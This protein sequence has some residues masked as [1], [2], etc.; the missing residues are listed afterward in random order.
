MAAALHAQIGPLEG[1]VPVE[2][3]AH[4]LDIGEI[5][6][7]RLDGLEG[8]LLTDRRRSFGSILANMAG[9]PRRARFT[10]AHELAHFLLERHE[11]SDAAGFA[12]VGA[13]MAEARAATTRQRQER[14]ANTF[15]IELLAPLLRMRPH[16]AGAADLSAAL[17]ARDD[18][19]ISL[20]AATWRYIDL[21]QAPLAAVVA[22]R[23][24][25]A[26]VLRDPRFPRLTLR[27]GDPLPSDAPARIAIGRGAPQLTEPADL[28]P[29]DWIGRSDLA[30][31]ARSHVGRTRRSVTLLALGSTW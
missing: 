6:K 15:A 20:E 27:R 26:Y 13:D 22:E 25:V 21:H 10:I 3:I 4:A 30:I 17:R 7:A 9:G 14:E 31:H 19:E 29:E 8:M 16:L 23:D 18:L 5:R 28:R 11:L 12:C 1:P 2:D 24:V